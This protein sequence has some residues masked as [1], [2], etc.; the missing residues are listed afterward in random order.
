MICFYCNFICY[1][2]CVYFDD[3]EKVLCCFMGLD[4][5]C[6]VCIMYCYWLEYRNFFYLIEYEIVIEMRMLDDLK[7]KYDKVVLGKFKL[8]VMI[9]EF[10]SS[11]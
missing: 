11:V 6:M 5:N 8:E 9:V 3:S 2:N 7:K 1:K 4:G 10:E